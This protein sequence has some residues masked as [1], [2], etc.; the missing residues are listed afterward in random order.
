MSVAWNLRFSSR[1][2]LEWTRPSSL[3]FGG[4]GGER[5]GGH[6][7]SGVEAAVLEGRAG[8]RGR[9]ERVRRSGCWIAES[10]HHVT[11]SGPMCLRIGSL[12]TRGHDIIASQR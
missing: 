12:P 1:L 10:R 2:S 9:R 4:I 3:S 11:C 6:R 5:A 7:R 8:A